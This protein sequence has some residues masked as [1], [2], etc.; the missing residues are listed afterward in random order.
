MLHRVLKDVNLDSSYNLL[1]RP[2]MNVV[3]VALDWCRLTAP[4]D[5][6]D[7]D[8][9]MS[10][11]AS[12]C[13]EQMGQEAEGFKLKPYTMSGFR[14]I[15]LGKAS[16]AVRGDLVLL[17]RRGWLAEYGLYQSYA[18]NF[19]CT[20]LDLAVDVLITD[21]RRGLCWHVMENVLEAEEKYRGRGAF[22]VPTLIWSKAGE[23]LYIG[24]RSSDKYFRL[25]D[26]SLEQGVDTNGSGRWYRFE[27]ELK[28]SVANDVFHDLVRSAD[29]REQRIMD[30]MS[31]YLGRFI[32]R[33]PNVIGE[34]PKCLPAREQMLSDDERT[35][36]W[37][38]RNVS[39][40]V[41]RLRKAGYNDVLDHLLDTERQ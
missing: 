27:L 2:L 31:G 11:C 25:Y 40:P 36:S 18:D 33:I 17:E 30:Y 5:M 41:A 6:V 26:K 22:P 15:S 16:K 21:G 14:G 29:K 35:L 39:K 7:H 3:G 8:T 10:D 19:R 28:R 37:I 9:T 4:A 1:F 32:T 38:A 13:Y 24:S 23:T 12:W 34:R 20:R